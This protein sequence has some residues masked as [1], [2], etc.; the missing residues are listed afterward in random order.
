MHGSLRRVGIIGATMLLGAASVVA[1]PLTTRAQAADPAPL[2]CANWR[3]GPADEPGY[4]PAEYDRDDYRW[5]SLRD[6]ALADS[7]HDLCGQM[8]VAADLA[9]GV[10]MGDP[11]V[12]IAILDSGIRWRNVDYMSDLANKVKI[13]LGEVQPSCHP[14]VPDGDCNGDGVFD[15]DDFGAVPD[16]NGNGVVDP[17]DLILNPAYANG[18]DDDANG[19]VDDIAGWDFLYGDNDPFDTVDYGHGS[20]EADDSVANDDGNRD[21][22][23]CP[24]CMF[25]PV[26]VGDSFIAD[27]QRF[28]AGVLFALDHDARVVQEALGAITNPSAAQQA[29]DLAYDRGVVTVASMADEASKHPNLSSSLEHTMTVN[30]VTRLRG[31]LLQDGDVEGYLALNGCTNFGGRTFVTVSS[32]S[33]SSEATGLSSGLMGLLASEADAAGVHL[34]ANEAMQVVRATADDIDFSTPNAHDPANDFGTPTGNPIADTVRYPSRPGWDGTFGYGRINAYEMVKAVRD[35]VIPPEA[36]IDAPAWFDVLGV[37]GTVAV[38]GHVAAPRADSYDYEVQWAAGMQG[39]EYPATDTWHTVGGQSGLA[40]PVDGT[41]AHL[42]LAEIAAALPDGGHG[43]PVDPTDRNRPDEEKFS[44][45]L[46]VVVT[47]HGGETDGL[48]GEMQKQIFVHDDPDLLPGLPTT[49][50]GA[51]S[52]SLKFVD[53]DGDGR[54]EL[55]VATNDGEIH[56]YRS[57]GSQLPGFPVVGDPSPFW[58]TWSGAAASAGIATPA[59]AFVM[60]APAVGDLDGDG[61]PEIVAADFN[62][63]VYV[64]SATGDRLATMHSVPDWSRDSADAQDEF[65]RTQPGFFAAPALGDL[66]GDGT[67]EIVAAGMD[68]HVYAWHHDGSTVAGFPVLV[69]DPDTPTAVDPVT[70]RVT[71]A[72]DAHA[73]EGGNLTVTPTLADLDG[74]GL[75]DIVVGAQE[76]YVETPN[77]GGDAATLV[78]LLGQLSQGGNSR[79]YAISSKGTNAGPAPAG[80]ANPHAGAYLPGWPVKVPMIQTGQLPVIGD[81]VAM[82]AAVGRLV[83]GSGGPQVAV[84]SAA[85]P[86]MV[87]DADGSGAYGTTPSGDVPPIWAAGMG[88]VDA[89]DFGPGRNSEDI[90]VTLVAFAGP[91][92]GD[93]TGDGAL[94]VAVPALGL[95]RMIDIALADL[96]LPNDDLVM[97][98]R[99]ADGSVLEGFPQATSD[100][101]FFVQPSIAD[102][103]GDGAA[104]V[105]AGNGVYT[106]NAFDARGVA[107]PGVAQAHRWLDGGYPGGGGL[108]R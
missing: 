72:V 98:H 102:I 66:D 83:P 92:L 32:S 71:F 48:R 36:M 65:N 88:N 90:A 95:S 104:E 53:L 42:D 75:V 105:L 101:A 56:A 14:V 94:D 61:S 16:L 26:R 30:S 7:P 69:V 51:G 31:G 41:L 73:E 103:D 17:E 25:L 19:Y 3:Y 60:G 27:G 20:G 89:Q 84:A 77:I 18:V 8:G 87:F 49:V 34:S 47:A 86:L 6:P 63:S 2:D 59:G 62:G 106:L 33:C 37:T 50:A 57:D 38:T 80:S 67:L 15:I 74:D 107:P 68:R 81:G 4:L 76:E 58:P 96:Q 40:S 39:P 24:R 5:T 21:V 1:V 23:T 91:A 54:D 82:P 100:M 13:N 29:I 99:G 28:A 11:S 108:G 64:W 78:A 44:V 35:G 43:A 45:R 93:L 46:R 85:G 52:S 10:T 9:W 22:G 97:A 55:L 70:H 12:V 79:L